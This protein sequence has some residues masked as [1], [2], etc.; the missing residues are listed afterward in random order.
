MVI[1]VASLTPITATFR[2]VLLGARWLEIVVLAIQV[3]ARA[4]IRVIGRSIP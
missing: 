4:S 1:L 2:I 3:S